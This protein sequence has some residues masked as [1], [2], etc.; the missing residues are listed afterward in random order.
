MTRR[1]G[2]T[3]ALQIGFIG[4]LVTCFAQV[5]FWIVDQVRYTAAVRDE[6]VSSYEREAEMAQHLFSKVSRGDVAIRIDQRFALADVGEAH[7]ALEA[8][9]TTGST[10]L[11]I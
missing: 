6:L 4:L 10:V 3:K 11:E 8:R 1:V 7:R 9:M 2:N 5:S